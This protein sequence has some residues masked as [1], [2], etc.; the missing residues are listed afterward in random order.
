MVGMGVL[1]IA[2]T[3]ILCF[4]F[5]ANDKDITAPAV[6][7]PLGFVPSVICALLFSRRWGFEIHLNTQLVIIGGIAL[8]S[9]VATFLGK[10]MSADCQGKAAVASPPSWAAPGAIALAC[11]L[12]FQIAVCVAVVLKVS[13]F[14]P[15]VSVYE[16]IGHF[17]ESKTFTTEYLSFGFP[18]N[19][20]VNLCKAAGYYFAFLVA[21][22]L[23]SRKL[24]TKTLLSIGNLIVSAAMGFVLGGRFLGLGYI[25]CT[26]MSYLMLRRRSGST[27][28]FK[29]L[30]IVVVVAAAMFLTLFQFLSFG[31]SGNI[32]FL[33]YIGIYLGAPIANLDAFLQEG[34]WGSSSPFGRMTFFCWYTY[35][36]GKLSI[37]DWQYAF[38]LPFR[39]M[40]GFGMG[41]VYTTFYSFAYDFGYLGIIVLTALMGF[42]SELV[43]E[44][45]LK[46]K[47][48]FASMLLVI[49]SSFISYQ[50][51]FS[52]FSDKFYEEVLTP[53]TITTAIY[54]IAAILLMGLPNILRRI[55]LEKSTR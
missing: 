34:G 14:F 20:I 49:Y 6:L 15:D 35:I 32:A 24:S 8:F 22:S 47:E 52:F 5:V 44:K 2:I 10:R 29:K 23:I 17:K 33:D 3:I 48:S 21:E 50:L 55:R 12:V 1:L 28:N 38:D 26:F 27:L 36:G 51:V 4:S 25:I 16:A 42:F 18:L 39:E 45:A 43:Y 41:N 40:A 7:F 54:M 30:V 37:A 46:I 9:L 19:Q 53:G 11:S 31:R 13:S